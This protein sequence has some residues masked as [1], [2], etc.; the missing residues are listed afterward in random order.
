MFK[1]CT[2]RAV[3]PEYALQLSVL[4]EHALLYCSM[5]HPNMGQSAEPGTSSIRAMR[6]LTLHRLNFFAR[7]KRFMFHC[8]FFLQKLMFNRFIS[9]QICHCR[10]NDFTKIYYSDEAMIC[11]SNL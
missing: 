10:V 7:V 9:T 3:N 1:S 4:P 5:F 11:N 6:R 2:Y 8:L